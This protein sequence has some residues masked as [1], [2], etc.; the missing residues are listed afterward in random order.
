MSNLHDYLVLLKRKYRNAKL[1]SLGD[2]NFTGIIWFF[3][4]ASNPSE[5]DFLDMCLHFILTQIVKDPTR[6]S[7]HSSTLLDLVL[8]SDPSTL[9]QLIYLP[10]LSDP[11][12]IQ[13][14]FTFNF[15]KR[16]ILYK[17]IVLYN[18]GNYYAINT[19]LQH[20]NDA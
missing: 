8:T 12:N 10:G 13:A 3:G 4:G 2:F 1:I 6:V 16:K 20:F 17:T 5:R 19:E 15:E 9:R 14:E 7:N 11:M 18:K